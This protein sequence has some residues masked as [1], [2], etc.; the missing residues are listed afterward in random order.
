MTEL[1]FHRLH[2]HVSFS[3][4]SSSKGSGIKEAESQQRMEFDAAVSRAL[5]TH[6]W[7]EIKKKFKN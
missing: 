5:G 6:S 4:K 3:A 1:C 7:V 2:P